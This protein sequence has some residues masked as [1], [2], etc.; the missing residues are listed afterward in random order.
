M[1]KAAST[2]PH[3]S[4]A[5]RERGAR[6]GARVLDIEADAVRALNARIERALPRARVELMLARSGRVV[7]IGMGKCGHIAR[8]IAATL[9]STGTPASSC[10]RPKPATA[11]SACHARRRR[12]RDLQLRRER[13]AARRSLPVIKRLGAKLIAMTGSRESALARD[14]DVHLDAARRA[15]SLPAQPRA[16][17]QHHRRAGARRRARRRAAR[18]ARLHAPRT[19][20][21]RIP[22]GAL[23]R[24]LLMHVRRRDAHRRRR[25]ARGRRTPRFS[26]ALRRDDAQ[27]PGHDRGGRRRRQRARHLHRRRP[28]PPAREGRRP[29]RAHGRR[30]D[31]A[32]ARAPSAPDALAVEAAQLMEQHRITSCWWST[33]DGA[34]RRRAQHAR[35]DARQGDLTTMHSRHDALARARA[36]A[37]DDL[38]RRRRAD[39]RQPLY[40]A[41]GEELKAFHALDGHGL[42]LLQRA[43]IACGA[44]HRPALG[45]R[46]RG[47]PRDLGIDARAP[48]RRRQAAPRSSN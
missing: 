36:R 41:G 21:A 13:R 26:E 47:A 14:A 11:T 10:T 25:A 45:V 22:G 18:R 44:D 37:P 31:D 35:P 5:T 39:R 43:G 42:K 20:R 8:K 23:G 6:A 9:A 46:S 32:P 3:D 12:A 1:M 30:R 4:L 15:G 2:T 48:G 29:A 24:Q 17:R 27:G 19:S 34:L 40:G 33:R 7:V 16:D 28:A 38:R